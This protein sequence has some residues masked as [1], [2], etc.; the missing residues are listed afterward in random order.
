MEEAP[1][2]LCLQETKWDAENDQFVKQTIGT[3]LDSYLMIKAQGTAGGVLLAWNSAIFTKLAQKIDLY[4]LSVDLAFNTDDTV[5]RITGTYGPS[6]TPQKPAFYRELQEARPTSVL[7]WM[8]CGDLN[9]TLLPRDRTDNSNHRVQTN[10]FRAIVDGLQLQD[11]KLQGRAY[12]WSNEQENPIFARLDRF[13]V[14]TAWSQTFPNSMQMA[15]SNTASDHCPLVCNV[16]TKFPTSNIFRLENSWI[17]NQEFKELVNYQ[18]ELAPT[19][20]TSTELNIKITG[21]RKA[22]I[23]WKKGYAEEF[24]Y[25]SNLCKNCLHWMAQQSEVRPLTNVETL[26][27]QLLLQRK[28]AN[29]IDVIQEGGVQHTQH[30]D[31]AAAVH[32]YFA[33]LMGARH[34]V[35]N[36]FDMSL[37]FT[38][39]QDKVQHMSAPITLQEITQVITKMGNNK[40]TGPDGLTAEFYKAF[41]QKIIPDL[42]QV[43]NNIILDP[44][45]TLH[46]LNDSHIILVPKK[47][48]ATE[49]ADFRLIS[50]INSVQKILSKI[51][52]NRLQLVIADFVMESQTGFIKGRHINQGFLYAQ[53]VVTLAT[54]QKK[55][56]AIFKAD[57][58]KAF[59][60]L[61]WDFLRQVLLAKG[62]TENWIRIINTST[63]QGT[64]KVVLN[65]VAGKNIILRRGVRQGDPMAPYLFIL[66]MDFLSTW[67]QHLVREGLFTPPF[68]DCKQCLLYAD[69]TLFLINPEDQQLNFLKIILTIFGDLSGLH[70]N[71][72]KSELIITGITTQEIGSKA[73]IMGCKPSKFPMKY[74][75][76]PLSNKKLDKSQ[77]Q[78]LI[79][80]ME[81]ILS[82]WKASLLSIGGRVTLINA[83][84]SAMPIYFMSTFMLPKWV[85]KRI[86]KIRRKFLWHGHKENQQQN[87]YISLV[88]W[89]TVITPK[90]KGGLG[91]KNL[92][93]MNSALMAKL[94]WNFIQPERQWWLHF[95][96]H[97]HR[98]WDMSGQTTLWK[99]ITQIRHFFETSVAYVVGSGTEILFW[100]DSWMGMPLKYQYPDLY[101]Q[102]QRGNLYVSEANNGGDWD[103][104][105]ETYLSQ[106]SIDQSEELMQQLQHINIEE[107]VADVV[108]WRWEMTKSFTVK[109]FYKGIEEYPI[110]NDIRA[111]AW[112]IGAPPRVLIFIWLMLRNRILTVD[113][114]VRRGWEIP[115]RCVLCK[116]ASESV[117]HL[118]SECQYTTM[119]IHHLLVRTRHTLRLTNMQAHYAHNI[120]NSGDMQIRRMQV[121][122]CFVVWRERCKRIFREESKDEHMLSMEIL[123]EYASW[124][125]GT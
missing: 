19:A 38:N 57:V 92:A 66:A 75:G 103:L 101:L 49:V 70:V 45:A 35:T 71:M 94:V 9:V 43:Y 25:Q 67:F 65:S 112:N 78:P 44:Q 72:Q 60:T 22:I 108:L 5:F 32:R 80:K 23:Q 34:M 3:R 114:L 122:I 53:E 24:K 18:W 88:A 17:R 124:F 6:T 119:V 58:F 28:R 73:V 11:L 15:I 2:I 104:A 30:K 96:P 99:S 46:P 13:M 26:L 29:L 102:A 90:I 52:A 8:V 62:F 115:N 16:Q 68:Q 51:L 113:N 47:Q 4:C 81:K 64:A 27:K 125:L 41:Q 37:L 74:L 107:T 111:R 79:T 105:L 87:R 20:T 109:S 100:H 89:D 82:T 48:G 33:K 95:L 91:I 76:M 86:D 120:V 63:L 10:R 55:Q 56:L 83:T 1:Q 31:K 85:L 50:L 118:Y 121:V 106:D 116:M 54:R 14:S 84:L 69:D 40:A 21:L 12:T 42:L 39:Q 98:P 59:D 110:V 97:A 61:S 7:P 123:E 117:E 93:T 77:Y 36:E